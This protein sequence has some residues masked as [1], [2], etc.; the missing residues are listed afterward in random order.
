MYLEKNLH[1]DLD[2]LEPG[3]KWRPVEDSLRI[4]RYVFAQLQFELIPEDFMQQLFPSGLLVFGDFRKFADC[5]RVLGYPRLLTL[6]TVDM[7]IGQPPMISAEANR[8]DTQF[9]RDIESYSQLIEAVK[10]C[11]IDYSRFGVGLLRVFKDHKDKAQITTWNPKEWVPVFYDDGT[12]RIRY[13]VIGWKFRDRLTVQI[14]DT[15]DGSYEEREYSLLSDDTISN[16]ID[17]KTYNKNTGKKLLYAIIN[18][19]TSTNPLGSSDY[20]IINA[21]LQKAIERLLA[22]LRVLDEHADPSMIGPYSLLESTEKGEK[23]FKTSKYYAVGDNEKEPQYLVW[24]ANLES[25]FKAFEELCKQIFTLSEM[26]EAFLGASGGTGNVVSGTAMRFKMISPL[27]K[28][29]RIVNS[30]TRPMQE[31]ISAMLAINNK[32]IDA[33]DINIAW[34]DPLPKDPREVAELAKLEAGSV[35]VKPL[36]NAIMDNFD[37]DE[38]SAQDYVDKILEDQA[39]FKSIAK[40]E[41]NSETGDERSKKAGLRVDDR[42]KGSPMDPRSEH[43]AKKNEKQ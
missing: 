12:N 22:I 13:N 43:W 23:V 14:H 33:K 18:T 3:H 42:K 21:L 25:S 35:A 30:F 5:T 27:E 36:I 6:K 19:P 1:Y 38:K 41:D 8:D 34:R 31:I 17:S 29:R 26:G 9:I 24:D 16:L 10:Q 40:T 11:I 39:A 28:A 15:E 7:V 32:E 20:E 2:F 37:L 4:D